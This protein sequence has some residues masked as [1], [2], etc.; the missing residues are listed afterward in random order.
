MDN[1]QNQLEGI[2]ALDLLF[3][4]YT[5]EQIEEMLQID[6]FN[7]VWKTYIDLEKLTYMQLW[8][9]Y[10]T[11]MNLETRLSLLEIAN[12]YYGQEAKEGIAFGLKVKRMFKEKYS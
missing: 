5:N 2:K 7:Y 8:E 12:K 6:D 4:N 10:N 9:L 3:Y 1:F 11:K